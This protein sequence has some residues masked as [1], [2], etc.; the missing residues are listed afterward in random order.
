MPVC[1]FMPISTILI[2]RLY[3]ILDFFNHLS[4]Q[5]HLVA[6]TMLL[7]QNSAMDIK[8]SVSAVHKCPVM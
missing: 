4:I 1:I 7:F 5:G 3:P 2:A 6:S 8:V